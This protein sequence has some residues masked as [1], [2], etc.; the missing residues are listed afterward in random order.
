M[1]LLQTSP[2][3]NLQKA[4]KPRPSC[5]H[6]HAQ[7][8]HVYRAGLQGS[9]VPSWLQPAHRPKAHCQFQAI[10]EVRVMLCHHFTADPRDFDSGLQPVNSLQAC[11][12]QSHK[13]HARVFG[14][15]P[16]S[17]NTHICQWHPVNC[18][19]CMKISDTTCTRKVQWLLHGHAREQKAPQQLPPAIH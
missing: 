4:I 10:D 3:S 18:S 11:D 12:T 14:V 19:C 7:L 15:S 16:P 1:A 17:T 9:M 2:G 8:P 13:S 6:Q 5:Y